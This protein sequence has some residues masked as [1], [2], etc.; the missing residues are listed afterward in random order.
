MATPQNLPYGTALT[1]SNAEAWAVAILDGLGAPQ[2]SANINSLIDWFGMEGGGGSNNPLNVSVASVG[3]EGAINSDGV[4]NIATPSDGVASTVAFLTGNNYSAIVSAFKSGAGIIGSKSA[5]VASELSSWS[6]GGYS[7]VSGSS[8][9]TGS[10][11]TTPTG[12]GADGTG[13]TGTDQSGNIVTSSIS[14]MW[15]DLRKL[16]HAVAVAIDYAFAMF[17]PGQ[18]FRTLFLLAALAIG[19][20]S[21]RVLSGSGGQ[22]HPLA[23]AAMA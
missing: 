8:D 22:S 20:F 5:T 21:F 15:D 11:A 7:S 17:E 16:V 12:T 18:G 14:N 4:Q 3:G 19:F 1:G 9:V 6:G 23:K 13:N 10:G 2:T